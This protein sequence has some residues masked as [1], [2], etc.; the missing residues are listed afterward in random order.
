M[1]ILSK[2]TIRPRIVLVETHGFRGAPTSEVRGI[3]EEI[4][5][6]TKNLGIAEPRIE[7]TCR[8]R[9]IKVLIGKR[10]GK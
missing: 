9:D 6:E 3:M 8:K 5:Y 10:N 2:M 1:E 7:E 4:G